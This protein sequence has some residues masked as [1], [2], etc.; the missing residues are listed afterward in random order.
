M[1][2][3]TRAIMLIYATVLTVDL[4]A[5]LGSDITFETDVAAAATCSNIAS[6]HLL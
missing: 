1:P 3:I 6:T 2:E 4:I 5:V